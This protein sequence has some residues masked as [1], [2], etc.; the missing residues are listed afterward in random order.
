MLWR[1]VVQSTEG[2]LGKRLQSAGVDC[3]HYADR[4]KTG[5]PDHAPVVVDLA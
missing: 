3:G 2:L 5:K 4:G 1:M